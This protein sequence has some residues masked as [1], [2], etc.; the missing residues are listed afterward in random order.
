MS[1][2]R[3]RNPPSATSEP[4]SAP[5]SPAL[6]LRHRRTSARHTLPST[7]AVKEHYDAEVAAIDSAV[8]VLDAYLDALN[9]IQKQHGANADNDGS[10]S[11]EKL[12]LQLQSGLKLGKRDWS[13]VDVLTVMGNVIDEN[14]TPSIEYVLGILG[15]MELPN[16][17]HELQRSQGARAFATGIRNQN[18]QRKKEA[19]EKKEAEERARE[20]QKALQKAREYAKQKKAK[21]K[22]MSKRKVRSKVPIKVKNVEEDATVT[23]GHETASGIKSGEGAVPVKET[24]QKD[25]MVIEKVP[26]KNLDADGKILNT[27]GPLVEDA[28]EVKVSTVPGKE[29]GGDVKDNAMAAVSKSVEGNQVV[30]PL[31]N[32]KEGAQIANTKT[33]AVP[34]SVGTVKE[35][36]QLTSS[37]NPSEDDKTGTKEQAPEEA[38]DSCKHQAPSVERRSTDVVGETTHRIEKQ[39]IS[40]DSLGKATSTPTLIAMDGK[41][42]SPSI[43]EPSAEMCVKGETNADDA[44]KASVTKDSEKEERKTSGDNAKAVGESLHVEKNEGKESAANKFRPSSRTRRKRFGN[45]PKS[46]TELGVVE[47]SVS[48]HFSVQPIG[49]QNMHSE[50]E[51]LKPFKSLFK[52]CNKG[53]ETEKS[54]KPEQVALLDMPNINNEAEKH[55]ETQTPYKSIISTNSTGHVLPV[56]LSPAMTSLV[57]APTS[58]NTDRDK[59]QKLDIST[60]AKED[61][62]AGA[63]VSSGDMDGM[64]SSSANKK[65]QATESAGVNVSK[66]PTL[67]KEL[68]TTEKSSGKEEEGKVKDVE[69]GNNS[70]N[71][72]HQKEEPRSVAEGGDAGGK[73]LDQKSVPAAKKMPASGTE[74]KNI[75]SHTTAPAP[76]DC[77]DKGSILSK[78]EATEK[79]DSGVKTDAKIDA[80]ASTIKGYSK[81]KVDSNSNP[82]EGVDGKAEDSE[83]MDDTKGS[84]KREDE[85]GKVS[86]GVSKTEKIERQDDESYGAEGSVTNKKETEEKYE[87]VSR[88]ATDKEMDLGMTME[89]VFGPFDTTIDQEEATKEVV[90]TVEKKRYRGKLVRTRKGDVTKEGNQTEKEKEKDKKKG[91]VKREES[92][93]EKIK[94]TGV[95]VAEKRNKTVKRSGTKEGVKARKTIE[96]TRERRVSSR[97]TSTIREDIVPS[98]APQMR[99]RR[100]SNNLIGGAWHLVSSDSFLL[101]CVEV[102]ETIHANKITIPFRE[103][104][105]SRD[106]PG[107]FDIVKRPMD[108]ST[109]KRR[110]EEGIVTSPE[111]FY[112]DMLLI[113]NNAVLFNDPESDLYELAMEM[114]SLIKKETKPILREWRERDGKGK[115]GAWSGSEK[116]ESESEGTK[117]RGRR[118]RERGRKKKGVR[119]RR[120]QHGEGE[121]TE[122]TEETVVV[123]G[124]RGR[125]RRGRGGRRG[126]GVGREKENKRGKRGRGDEESAGGGRVKKRRLSGRRRKGEDGDADE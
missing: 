1:G 117:I 62:K 11:H 119:L 16:D 26:E 109:V 120:K 53:S 122:E 29:T 83:R 34:G 70:Q 18:I 82:V 95:N 48:N 23:A 78:S 8:G 89:E 73:T 55:S 112:D 28:K 108:L 52:A 25:R 36:L 59:A 13:S 94:A 60:S 69:E 101:R 99:L 93:S 4:T 126:G 76:K 31:S 20:K 27:A 54:N 57:A 32:E 88:R 115:S 123:V 118:D 6:S 30:S 44:E 51:P 77:N 107:Y 100:E 98:N 80:P 24:D 9:L 68:S 49:S 15:L 74:E 113:C 106:A 125:G 42:K 39:A 72:M 111:E 84:S 102:W 40:D 92:K 61:S 17:L 41:E 90:E 103:P 81:K 67:Q 50:D 22:I 14:P 85:E 66:E 45:M 12:Q 56:V 21:R 58:D 121:E 64:P 43:V 87:E 75:S 35:K 46:Q 37:T 91:S 96:K 114:R 3:S 105:T 5:D 104:V 7:K 124:K 38:D 71:D 65:E 86:D 79:E 19:L 2:R 63:V 33:S 10:S 47:K 116:S 110:M 97:R